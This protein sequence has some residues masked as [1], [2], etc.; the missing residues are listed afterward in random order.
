VKAVFDSRFES[1]K[2][3][4]NVDAKRLI[5]NSLDT[6]DQAPKSLPTMSS[7]QSWSKPF[8]ASYTWRRQYHRSSFQI[9]SEQTRPCEGRKISEAASRRNLFK[10]LFILIS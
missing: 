3:H 6:I 8:N 1:V 5:K 7:T 2:V 9:F 10:V 4:F